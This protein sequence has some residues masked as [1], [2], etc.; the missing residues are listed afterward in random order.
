MSCGCVPSMVNDRT[1]PRGSPGCGPEQAQARHLEQR[2]V[3][4][5]G[6]RLLVRMDRVQ[7]ADRPR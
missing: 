4:I 2:L 7:A 5:G 1:P 6:Q 3:P